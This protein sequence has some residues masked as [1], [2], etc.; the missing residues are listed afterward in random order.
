M[1][2]RRSSLRVSSSKI[3]VEVCGQAIEIE[4]ISVDAAKIKDLTKL[5]LEKGRCVI[6]LNYIKLELNFTLHKRGD[7]YYMMFDDISDRDSN[8]L[9]Q[10]LK[11]IYNAEST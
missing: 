3:V 11:N 8:I 10:A 5:A 1:L 7:E 6:T 2:E 4:D 9:Q